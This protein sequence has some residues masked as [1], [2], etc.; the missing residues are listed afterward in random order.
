MGFLSS[1]FGNR[2]DD[3]QL[4]MRGERAITE[5]PRIS[6]FSSL[7]VSSKEGI[8]TLHGTVSAEREKVYVEDCVRHTLEGS[9]LK[10]AQILNQISTH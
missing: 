1:L 8:V 6:T 7:G 9:G 5:D 10:Y 3:E 4:V 2:Y